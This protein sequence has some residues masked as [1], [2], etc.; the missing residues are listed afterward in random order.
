[1]VETKSKWLS[2]GWWGGIVAFISA[3]AVM[4]G[5][6]DIAVTIGFADQAE[7]LDWLMQGITVVGAAFAAYGRKNATKVLT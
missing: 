4:F 7:L 6:P 1:M 5:V 2:R 3:G